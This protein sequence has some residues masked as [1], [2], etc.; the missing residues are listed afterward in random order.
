MEA[1]LR[2][3]HGIELRFDDSEW[4]APAAAR[5]RLHVQ[6]GAVPPAVTPA[7]APSQWIAE[8]VLA[9]GLARSATPV[10]LQR[11]AGARARALERGA[12]PVVRVPL[13]ADEHAVLLVESERV[14]AWQFAERVEEPA[15]AARIAHANPMREA[16]FVLAEPGRAAVAHA[17]PRELA[18][19]AGWLVGAIEATVIKFV[20]RRAASSLVAALESGKREG[21]VVLGDASDPARWEEPEAFPFVAAPRAGP[22]RILLFVHGTFSSVKAGFGTLCATDAGRSFLAS[23]SRRYGAVWGWDHRTLSVDPAGNARRLFEALAALTLARPPVV[24]IVCHSRGALVV[25]HL[26]EE[27]L[28]TKAW[29]PEIGRVVFIA[30]ANAGTPLAQA[31][32]WRALVDLLTN[33]ALAGQSALAALGAPHIAA[34]AAPLVDAIAEFVGALAEAGVDPRI[35]PGLAALDPQGPFVQSLN[36]I[37]PGEPAAASCDYRVVESDFQAEIVDEATH[38]PAEFPR[39]LALLLANGFADALMRDAPNDL[40]VDV[41]SMAAINRPAREVKDALDFGRNPLVYHTNYLLQPETLGALARWLA[42]GAPA[43][44]PAVTPARPRGTQASPA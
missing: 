23:A 30:G 13:A 11:V 12:A 9:Q 27:V 26:I 34:L 2:F 24:D 32:N 6:P 20:A 29:R 19:F 42:I 16:I 28:P 5:T 8:R 1:V 21:P 4:H 22:A 10:S 39:R 37:D 18:P 44:A 35:A 40:V 36:R 7:I 33:L 31:A 41:P 17:G 15:P 25:R 38:R 14:V 3:E 43:P